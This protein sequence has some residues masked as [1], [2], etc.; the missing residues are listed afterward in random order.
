ME[1]VLVIVTNHCFFCL[2][3]GM[4]IMFKYNISLWKARWLSIVS[5]LHSFSFVAIVFMFVFLFVLTVSQS[6]AL[7]WLGSF[8]IVCFLREP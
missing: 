6:Q 7:S 5:L 2:F 8:R 3:V 4:Y 1:I